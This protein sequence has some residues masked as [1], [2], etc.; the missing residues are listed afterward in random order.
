MKRDTAI[1]ASE[2]TYDSIMTGHIG[3]ESEHEEYRE[4]V[5]EFAETEVAP[6]VDDYEERDEFPLDL[7]DEL[8]EAGLYGVTIPER[9]GGEG[10]DYRSFVLT[11]EELCRIWKVPAGVVSLSGSLVGHTLQKFGSERQRE[12]WL[13]DVFTQNQVTAVSLTE[14][15]AG[16]DANALETTAERDGDEFVI[17]GHKVWTSHGEVADLIFVVARTDDT[18]SHDDV[19]II[20]VPNPGE[21]D[22]VEF[23]RDIPCMEGGAVV[24]NEVKYENLRVPVENLVGEEG[25]GFRYIMEALD[26]GRLGVAAQSTGILQ[27]CLD[28]SARFA[29]EREQFGEPIRNNQGVSFKLADMKMDLEAARLLT[30][31]AAAKLD[32]GERVTQDAAIAKTFASDAAME[33]AVE[34]VQVLGS[35]GYS[36]DY[37]VERFMREAKGTQ[38][39]EGTNEINRSV[40]ARH[41]YD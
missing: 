18:G 35:R 29:D 4:R 9:Y 16:S 10:R 38:I 17:D 11:I 6:V 15:Q 31:S 24:E 22:G 12:E 3:L 32:A 41:L 36:K 27:G 21:R 25:R 20:G 39:Y 13:T 33:G 14:P 1:S 8:G 5:R 23:V 28:E 7:V 34:A 19:S 30:Y 40:V 2:T 26:I 37:P